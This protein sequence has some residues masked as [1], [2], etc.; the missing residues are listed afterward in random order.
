METIFT[1][2][3]DIVKATEGESNEKSA[4]GVHCTHGAGRTGYMII[5][6]LMHLHPNMDLQTA[7]EAFRTARDPH[8]IDKEFLIDH[9]KETYHDRNN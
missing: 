3:D 9:L 8:F 2:V 5:R 1:K 6:M 7:F 4:I